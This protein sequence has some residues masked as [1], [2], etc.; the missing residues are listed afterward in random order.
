VRNEIS[1]WSLIKSP[2]NV[3]DLYILIL[4]SKRHFFEKVRPELMET[5]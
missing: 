4:H 1:E 3:F 2:G 5:Y